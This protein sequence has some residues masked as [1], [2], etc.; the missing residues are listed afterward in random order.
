MSCLH[1]FYSPLAGRRWP[2]HRSQELKDKPYQCWKCSILSSYNIGSC[3]HDQRESCCCSFANLCPNLCEPMDCSTPG[4]PVHHQLLE[5]AQT[6]VH[7]V[8]DAIQPCHS[9]SSPSP[10]AINL[11]QHQGLFINPQP[12]G[13]DLWHP[14]Y[15]YGRA[16]TCELEDS[17]PRISDSRDLDLMPGI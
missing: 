11:S 7:Q 12:Q 2:W 4:L 6:L 17:N 1:F 13:V 15:P 3:L 8:S 5:L 10:P 16:H 14:L 9:L